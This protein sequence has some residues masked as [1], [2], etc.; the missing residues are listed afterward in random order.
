MKDIRGKLGLWC[1][2]GIS[3]NKFLSKMASGMKKPLGITELWVHDVPAKLWPLNVR[4]MYGIGKKTAQL[5]AKINI[6]TIGEL[7]AIDPAIL[8][9]NL[10]RWL[11]RSIKGPMV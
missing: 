6:R 9:E 4:A 11:L 2:I 5:L 7:A 3:E 10:E 8:S 1:S